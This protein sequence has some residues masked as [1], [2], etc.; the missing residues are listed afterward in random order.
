MA[1]YTLIGGPFDGRKFEIR[2]A[3]N[4]FSLPL[5]ATPV[6]SCGPVFDGTMFIKVCYRREAWGKP[7]HDKFV[8]V[9]DPD[10]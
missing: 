8:Y 7:T 9:D 10:A 5:S 3:C 4:E 1:K 2:D 6:C